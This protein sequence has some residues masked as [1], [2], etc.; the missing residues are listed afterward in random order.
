[1]RH[2]PRN[3]GIVALLI[4]LFLP[5]PAFAFVPRAGENV[6][7]SQTIQDD[8]YIAGGTVT[9][10]GTVDGDVTA[11][12][13]TVT[14][15]SRVSGALLVAGGT[16]EIGGSVGRSIRAAGG[17]VRLGATAGTDAV[18]AGGNVTVA[19]TG[20][21]GRDLVAGGGSVR[22][23]GTVGR[24]ALVGGGNV[25]VG[26]S[27][28]GDVD[29]QADRVVVLSTARIAG[30]LRYAAG[31][32][33][34]IQSGALISGGIERGAAVRPG[35]REIA[36][37]R[38]RVRGGGRLGGWLGLLAFGLVVFALLPRIPG[39]GLNEIRARFGASL[40][41]GFVILA[42]APAAA[43]VLLISIVGIPLAVTLVLLWLLTCYAGQLVVATW[44][45][46]RVLRAVRGG[47]APSVSWTLV[48]GV[49]ILVILYAV[50]VLGWLVRLVAVMTGL[51][52]IW[53]G[54][55]R[56]TRSP[57]PLAPA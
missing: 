2:G 52:A 42:A 26:G 18:L 36:P 15:I 22:I 1:M 41:T 28:Q 12:G 45:G 23:T 57:A 54:V 24:N 43:I 34:E 50:P 17:T 56:S 53:L 39:G 33:A 40:L 16:V 30:R 14:V 9:V 38:T 21:V 47:S 19:D 13:G 55:W 29:V 7:F 31:G 44:L 5:W 25:V 49:T 46:E 11:A 48:V 3:G 8:L 51:G 4:F 35:M 20:R 27:V 10:T 37:R 6:T 32:S